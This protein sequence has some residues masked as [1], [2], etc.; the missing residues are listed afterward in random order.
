MTAPIDI[1]TVLYN[2]TLRL[3]L[4]A[5]HFRTNDEPSTSLPAISQTAMPVRWLLLRALDLTCRP[6]PPQKGLSNNRVDRA[7]SVKKGSHLN[8]KTANP[9]SPD[10]VIC[11]RFVSKEK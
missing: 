10:D 2:L 5:F 9:T 8:H 4:C 11:S 1:M 7:L 3:L 6:F